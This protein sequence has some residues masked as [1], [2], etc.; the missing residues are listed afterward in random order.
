MFESGKI[1]PI[2]KDSGKFVHILS[3]QEGFPIDMSRQVYEE[4]GWAIDEE[5]LQMCIN[6]ELI[7]QIEAQSKK[8][9]LRRD[10]PKTV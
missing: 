1:L 4:Y 7:K 5:Q 2:Q 6:N 10:Q 3:M 9:D 8:A